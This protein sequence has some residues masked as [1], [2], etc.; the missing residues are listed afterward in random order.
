[1]GSEPPIEG[2]SAPKEAVVNP[3]YSF[4]F[5][6]LEKMSTPIFICN[7]KGVVIFKNDAAMRQIRL[8]R[9]NT[10]VRSHLRQAEE[11]EL[12]RIHLRKKPSILT[13]HT[14]DR[15]ARAL[16]IPYVRDETCG[17][18]LSQSE[19]PAGEVCSLW[20]FPAILQVYPTSL[21]VQYMEELVENLGS[22]ICALIKYADRASGL[23][24]G[25]E[26]QSVQTKLDRKVHRILST[27]EAMPEGR[28]FDLRHSLQ[29]ILPVLHRRLEIVGAELEYSEEEDIHLPGQAVDLPRMSL[30]LLHLLTYTVSLSGSRSVRLRLC[31]MGDEVGMRASFTLRWPPFTT[32]NSDDLY[33]LCLLLPSGQLELLILNSIC[34]GFG[35]S[36]TYTLTDEPEY[37]LILNVGLPLT[38]RALVRTLVLTPTEQLFLERDLE[39]LFGAV[40]EETLA[41]HTDENE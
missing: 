8:P 1:M 28:W 22:E 40:W 4:S 41:V 15:P 14:G 16:V 19:G 9:R 33:K 38:Q 12:S 30:A 2:F 37:N 24:A 7:A 29:I 6:S 27:L 26:A 11:G 10:S 20:I 39:A 21:P 35:T 18:A 25:K 36:V 5:P 31:R 32:E 13:M 17:P 3:S 34:K 23:F